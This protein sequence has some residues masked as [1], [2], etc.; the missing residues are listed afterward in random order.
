VK[1]K[2]PG[3]SKSAGPAR[4]RKK[5]DLEQKIKMLK[6]YEGCQSLSS[7]ARELDLASSTAKSFRMVVHA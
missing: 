7:I 4:K 5:I 3:D 6:K 1:G 2:R